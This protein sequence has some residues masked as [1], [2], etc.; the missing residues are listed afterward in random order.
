MKIT[1]YGHACLLIEDN[2]KRLLIDPG[3]FAELKVEGIGPVDVIAITHEHGDHVVADLIRALKPKAVISGSA[4]KEMLAKE[5][6]EAQVLPAGQAQ[7]IEGFTIEAFAAQHEAIPFPPPENMAY[8]IN[9]RLLHTG[10]S[11]FTDGL[12]QPE[13][14]AVP[15]QGPWAKAVDSIAF[16]SKL[17]P[18]VAI[19]VHNGLYKT[20]ISEMFDGWIGGKLTEAGIDYKYLGVGESWEG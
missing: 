20:E 6:I 4:V 11:Y 15:T 13:I 9:N 18:K 12:P 1:K 3:S 2:G 17:K 5:Q 16:A 19:P 10:D 8:F 7:T 14:L